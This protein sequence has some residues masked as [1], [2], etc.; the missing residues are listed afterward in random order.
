MCKGQMRAQ[1]SATLT[2]SSKTLI[3]VESK[4]GVDEGRD[5]G[6][7]CNHEDRGDEQEDAHDGAEPPLLFSLEK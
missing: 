4:E 1:L 3:G 7:V 5:S 6:A 2:Q